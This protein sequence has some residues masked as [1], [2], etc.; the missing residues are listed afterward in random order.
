MDANKLVQDGDSVFCSYIR[1]AEDIIAV[2]WNARPVVLK[3]ANNKIEQGQLV[4]IDGLDSN[5]TLSYHS[6][7]KENYTQR[8]ANNS[9]GFA[10]RVGIDFASL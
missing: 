9:F 2:Q 8:M 4:G 3:I 7:L 5:Y 6:T 1:D 10:M